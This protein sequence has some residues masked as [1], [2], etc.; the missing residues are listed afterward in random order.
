VTSADGGNGSDISIGVD[1][2]VTVAPASGPTSVSA[3]GGVGVGATASE[4][5]E[6]ASE[7]LAT[8]DASTTGTAVVAGQLHEVHEVHEA[9][10]EEVAAQ[11]GGSNATDAAGGSTSEDSSSAVE[12]PAPKVAT[13]DK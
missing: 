3:G 5:A 10:P 2:S 8:A 1:S 4:T 12:A 13:A 6:P 7:I 9:N 11:P